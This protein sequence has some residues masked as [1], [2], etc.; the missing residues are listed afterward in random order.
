MKER[1]TYNVDPERRRP[2]ITELIDKLRRQNPTWRDDKVK[3]KAKQ[4]WHERNADG[5]R[6]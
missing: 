3:A 4:L 5:V 2:G 6:S 1:R